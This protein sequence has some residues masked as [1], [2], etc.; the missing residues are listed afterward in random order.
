MI[1]TKLL[2]NAPT[3]EQQII[4]VGEGGGYFDINRVLWDERIDGELP[5]ITLGGMVRVD[6]NLILDETLLAKSVK[7]IDNMKAEEVRS[8]RTALLRTTDWTGLSD[9]TMSAAWAAY[10][11]ELRDIPEQEGFPNTVVWPEEP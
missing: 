8:Q 6:N 10:R 1:M 9:V 5:D 11:Q 4:T 7:A 3:G 2:V